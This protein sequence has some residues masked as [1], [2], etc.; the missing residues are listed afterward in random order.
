MIQNK[1]E[2]SKKRDIKNEERILKKLVKFS[3]TQSQ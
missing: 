2:A 3:K 1:D